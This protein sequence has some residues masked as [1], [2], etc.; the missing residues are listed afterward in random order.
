MDQ[1]D[2]QG[3]YKD[4]KSSFAS[5]KQQYQS[6]PGVSTTYL[7]ALIAMDIFKRG[8]P[9]VAKTNAQKIETLDPHYLLPKQIIA[10]ASIFQANRT[11]SLSYLDQ[12]IDKDA[13]HKDQYAFYKSV[14]QYFIG[15]YQESVLT[16]S[17]IQSSEMQKQIAP[18]LFLS[19]HA[20]QDRQQLEIIVKKITQ[21]PLSAQEYL[22][23]FYELLWKQIADAPLQPE[24]QTS[25][26][27][28][29]R[30]CYAQ[31]SP[32]ESFV[33][34]YGKSAIMYLQG[35]TERSYDALRQVV[36]YYP[37]DYLYEALAVLATKQ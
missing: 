15:A 13:E 12:L 19:Y 20:L 9:N 30:A 35:E 22:A 16:A 23:F 24:I 3:I 31:V 36:T 4:W 32:A 34:L 10:Y 5:I 37:Q 27:E 26:A 8:Y 21:Q 2:P 17:Q 6:Y 33:C 7:D 14:A 28:L 11:G 1:L 29:L 18:Y 25:L